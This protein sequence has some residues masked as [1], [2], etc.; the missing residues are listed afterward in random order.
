MGHALE[1][2]VHTELERRKADLGYVKTAG[3]FEV[4]FLARYLGGGEDLIQVCADPSAAETRE[5]ELRALRDAAADFPRATLRLL[6]LTRDHVASIS[7]PDVQVQPAYEWLL[8][9]P[10]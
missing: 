8:A 6:V 9:A 10:A 3:G 4:D 7:A 1:T 5:R 2:V